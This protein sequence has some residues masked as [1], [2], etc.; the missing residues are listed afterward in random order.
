MSDRQ[1][2]FAVLPKKN[3][4][5]FKGAVS[6]YDQPRKIRKKRRRAGYL[7]S[8]LF[9]V[10]VVRPAAPDTVV[11]WAL[12][13]SPMPGREKTLA[14]Q[15]VKNFDIVYTAAGGKNQPDDFDEWLKSK[16]LQRKTIDGAA[17]ESLSP[18]KP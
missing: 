10:P 14:L 2:Y 13:W 15:L 17:E 12:S 4:Q 5:A 7:V 1:N 8:K 18:Q 16:G 9:S 11:G 6:Q 3:V